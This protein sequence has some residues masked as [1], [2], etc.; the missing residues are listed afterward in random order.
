MNKIAKTA[1][2]MAASGIVIGAALPAQAQ[3][4]VPSVQEMWNILQA[5]QAKIDALETELAQTQVEQIEVKKTVETVADAVETGTDGSLLGGDTSIG[6]YGELHYEGGAKDSIDFHR[7][8]LFFGH[9]FTDKIRL[10]SELEVEHAL[11]GNGKPGEV[12]LEQ[13]YLEMDVSDNAQ[14]FGGVHLIPVG[15]INETHEPPTFF[16]VERNAVEKNIIP[17]TWWEAGLGT[18]G[19]VG[20]SGFSYDA[21]VS[22]GLNLN[23]GNGYKIRSGRQKVAKAKMK[24]AAYTGRIQ[25]TGIPGVQL[26][27]SLFYQPDVT[28][29]LGDSITGDSVS[30]LLWTSHINARYKGF[31]LRALHAN[32]SLDGADVDLSGRD[33]QSGFYIEPAYRLAAPISL[34]Q[35]AEIGVF[36]RYSDWDNNNGLNNDSGTHRNVFGINYWPVPELV[37]KLDYINEKKESGGSSN[38]SLNLGLGY[39]F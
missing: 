15:M 19:N 34:L 21:M 16:G 9:E 3:Q 27:S 35:D 2:M 8:V 5:Q 28:Q 4:S 36:Y 14:V 25:Y 24:S 11:S 1:L 39:Q 12:E 10:F 13:A 26:S 31:G 33:K 38:N 37:F 20:S 29:K 7:F 17:A 6:G 32:W 30:A 18:S 22:S 23:S